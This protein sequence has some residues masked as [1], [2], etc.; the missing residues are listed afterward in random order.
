MLKASLLLAGLLALSPLARGL[1]PQEKLTSSNLAGF[2]E[3]F[4]GNFQVL[5]PAYS[6]LASEKL[7]LRDESGQPLTRRH[8]EDRRKLLA[9]LRQTTRR[10][11]SHPEDLVAALTLMVQTEELADDLYDLSQIAYDNDREVL[12]KRFADLAF[13]MDG[14]KDRLQR[15]T[16]DLAARVEERLQQLEKENAKPHDPLETQPGNP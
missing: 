16:L 12:A 8:I 14:N 4:G 6:E 3:R 11:A 2:L 13:T 15:Y 9:D 1:P 5:E 10:L 7:P